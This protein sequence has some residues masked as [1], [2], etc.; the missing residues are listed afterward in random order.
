[1][2]IDF[3]QTL[4]YTDNKPLAIIYILATIMALMFSLTI[5]ECAHGWVAKKCGDQTAYMNGRVS[6]S[7]FAHIDPI[8]TLMMLLVGFGW[9][10]P[11]PVNYRNLRKPKRDIAL[12]SLAGPM[13]NILFAAVCLLAATAIF[14][15]SSVESLLKAGSIQV[16]TYSMLYFLAQLNAGLAVFN[17]IPMPPLDGSK[18]VACLMP[19]NLAARYLSW[20]RYSGM[21]MFV[22]VLGNSLP[23]IGDIIGI[24]W[25]PISYVRDTLLV[26]GLWDAFLSFWSLF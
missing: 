26:G 18:V 2:I 23:V 1:M 13:S 20:E 19:N 5:H 9:A 4:L 15:F 22:I 10:K 16:I 17:L 7:P 3:V 6:L 24:I 11:V 21:I 14:R 25:V 8:G 12:V